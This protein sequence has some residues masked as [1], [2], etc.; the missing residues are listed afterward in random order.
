MAVRFADMPVVVDRV[1]HR[2]PAIR[3]GHGAGKNPIV[4]FSIY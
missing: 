2:S 4:T 1:D 3:T